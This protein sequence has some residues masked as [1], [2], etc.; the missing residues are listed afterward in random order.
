M[1]QQNTLIVKSRSNGL[2][3]DQFVMKS[4]HPVA[5]LP[6]KEVQTLILSG[7]IQL[8]GKSVRPSHLVKP[9]DLVTVLQSKTKIESNSV[10]IPQIPV[11]FE[12]Q[13]FLVLNK[14]AGLTMH[15]ARVGQKG[16]LV[17]WILNKYPNLSQ[18]GDDPLRPGIVHRLDKETSGLVLLAKTSEAYAALK[19]LFGTRQVEKSYSALVYGKPVPK[20]GTITLSLG[21]VAGSTRRG[22]PMKKR[23]FAGKLRE[24]VTEY[25]LVTAYPQYSLLLIKPKTGRT[26]QIRVH[27]ASIGHPVVGDQLYAFKRH[28]KGLFPV[29]QLLHARRLVFSLF[30]EKFDFECSLPVRFDSF[31]KG[32]MTRDIS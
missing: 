10:P 9:G 17:D 22:T 28:K 12:N 2:R 4:T 3:L 31:L 13:H 15:P 1:T 24:A 7:K 23:A 30:G 6:R 11:V 32:E 20:S 16:T 25:T 14:P 29:H 27:L 21:R 19:E 18:V 5:D 26:H 8:N